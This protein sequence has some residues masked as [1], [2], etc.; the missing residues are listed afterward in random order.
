MLIDKDGKLFRMIDI[1]Y[2]A[3]NKLYDKENRK[4]DNYGKLTWD[5]KHLSPMRKEV[6]EI[7]IVR[8]PGTVNKHLEKCLEE[9]D[10]V[11]MMEFLQNNRT[12]VNHMN[13]TDAVQKL[14]GINV[15]HL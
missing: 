1:S 6:V 9:T 12:T 5:D 13:I 10:D 15:G 3:D 8:A 7:I 14:R 11:I 2:P 4:V